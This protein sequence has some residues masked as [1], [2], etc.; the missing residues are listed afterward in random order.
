MNI[1][2]FW[3][4]SG[5]EAFRIILRKLFISSFCFVPSTVIS[6]RCEA[7][8]LMFT[9]SPGSAKMGCSEKLG[10]TSMSV[11]GWLHGVS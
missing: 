3:T 1:S 7:S 2:A 5:G 6:F 10:N 8:A 11:D 9:F 4:A